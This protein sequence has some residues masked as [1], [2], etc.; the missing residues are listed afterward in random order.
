MATDPDYRANHQDSQKSWRKR[1]HNYWRK[2]RSRHPNYCQRNR[3]LQ[4]LRDRKRRFQNLAKMDALEHLSSIKAGTY[5]L[6]PRL[7]K[8]DVLAQKVVLIPAA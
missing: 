4:K 6:L 2:Y 8:M 1:N 7:A 3:L 5:Y